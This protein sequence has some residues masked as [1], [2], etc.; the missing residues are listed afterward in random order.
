MSTDHPTPKPR[1][2]NERL[3]TAR[4]GVYYRLLKDGSRSYQICFRSEGRLIWKTV[5]GGERDAVQAR[6]KIISELGRGK[7]IAPSGKTFAEFAAEWFDAQKE[8]LDERTLDQYE[9]AL[10]LHLVPAFGRLRLTLISEDRVAALIARMRREGYKAWTIKSTLIPLNGILT[11]AVRL[12]HIA[13]NPLRNLERSE[14]PR[15][16]RV[17]QRVLNTP[18]ISRLLACAPGDHR[19]LLA[20]AILTGARQMELLA[21]RWNEVDFDARVIRIREQLS[22]MNGGRKALK[23]PAA[24]RDVVLTDTLAQILREH[25]AA[26]PHCQ[27]HDYVFA[28][29]S[30][31]PHSWSNIIKRVLHPAVARAGIQGPRPRWHDLR[32]TFASLLIA[33]GA[34]VVFVARQLGHTDPSITLK[35]YAHLFDAV[36]HSDRFRTLLDEALAPVIWANAGVTGDGSRQQTPPAEVLELSAFSSPRKQA[37]ASAPAW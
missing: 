3:K 21:L 32:H 28:T 30:G 37:A 14:R 7:K 19:A 1:R 27:D 24:R 11:R 13:E 10:R 17:E 22:R 36:R 5:P 6:A 9:R 23:T 31:R 8:R 12:G 16:E 33:Q 26:S 18:E 29:S 34:D 15:V 25:K 20:T 4:E 2:R 35:I